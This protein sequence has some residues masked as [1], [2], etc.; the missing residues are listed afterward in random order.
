[1]DILFIKIFQSD[2]LEDMM[3]L[4]E[5]LNMMVYIAF[6]EDRKMK[7]GLKYF[8]NAISRRK[9]GYQIVGNPFTIRRFIA[10]LMPGAVLERLAK[11]I[12]KSVMAVSYTHLDVYKRQEY[13]RRQENGH[14]LELVISGK[15]SCQEISHIR[16]TA[17]IRS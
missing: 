3:C 15:R 6:F 11:Q 14:I 8:S 5:Y 16:G 10:V 7:E 4:H 1:M 13:S 17:R 9:K 12:S 2:S